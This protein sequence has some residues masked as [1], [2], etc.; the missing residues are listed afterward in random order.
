M[1]ILEFSALLFVIS[2]FTGT[3]GVLSSILGVGS[4]AVKVFAMDQ[5]LHLPYKISTATSNFMVGITVSASIGI[6]FAKDYIE[7]T[8][9]F[10]VVLGI[11][12]GAL[13]GSKIL[14][15][16]KSRLLRIVFSLIVIVLAAQMFYMGVKAI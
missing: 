15:F 13:V 6:Y 1:T 11:F 5:V 7:P 2:C 4:G 16:A 10:P 9:T 12:L 8:I 3:F 14:Q